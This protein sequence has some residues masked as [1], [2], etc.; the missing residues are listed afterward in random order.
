[1]TDGELQRLLEIRERV[2]Q[3]RRGPAI[4]REIWIAVAR[5]V[6][7]PGERLACH[8]CGKFRSIAQAHHVVPLTAQYDRGFQYPDHEFVW[9]CP[10]H[11]VM[12]HLFIPG[13]DRSMAISALRARGQTT[14]ALNGDLSQDEFNRMM[15]LM[16]QSARSPE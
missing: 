14:T 5:R 1:M 2:E 13:D 16:R 15:D 3:R 4:E 11:H 8:V 10:N 6:F 9:L 7:V 12:A